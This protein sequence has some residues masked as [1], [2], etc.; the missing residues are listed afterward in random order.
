MFTFRMS[1][2]EL[3]ILC[4]LLCLQGRTNSTKI[5]IKKIL[6]YLKAPF[7]PIKIKGKNL[8]YFESFTEIEIFK[9][10]LSFGGLHTHTHRM[11]LSKVSLWSLHKMK[12]DLRS[13]MNTSEAI[14]GNGQKIEKNMFLLCYNFLF[15][16][17]TH[18]KQCIFL[19]FNK[20]FVRT[21]PSCVNSC[22][23]RTSTVISELF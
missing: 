6:Y 2:V 12:N 1:N 18:F 23:K 21:P 19:S 9:S 16:P 10:D 22:T 8:F 7:N 20:S 5:R 4:K 17:S 3:Y 11:I 13:C 14:C 15:F